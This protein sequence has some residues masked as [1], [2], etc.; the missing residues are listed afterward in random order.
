MRVRV[1]NEITDVSTS[2]MCCLLT[3][4]RTKLAVCGVIASLLIGWL[5][6]CLIQTIMLSVCRRHGTFFADA[7]HRNHTRIKFTHQIY[8]NLFRDAAFI[9]RSDLSFRRRST[10]VYSSSTLRLI[11]CHLPSGT[12]SLVSPFPVGKRPHY[13]GRSY[14]PP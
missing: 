7:W 14:L 2:E 1:Q 5:P 10:L 3:K 4:R 11:I 9:N 13:V 12:A 6:Q 8:S